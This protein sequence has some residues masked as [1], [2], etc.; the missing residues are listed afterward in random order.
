MTGHQRRDGVDWQW[1][2]AQIGRFLAGKP[3]VTGYSSLAAGTDQIFADVVLERGGKLIAVIPLEGYSAHF[4]AEALQHF[5]M[6]SSK[7]QIVELKSAKSDNWAFLDAGKWIVREADSII[8]VWDGEPA[9]G[10]GGTGDIVTYA[11]SVGKKVHHI[12]P[13]KRVTIDL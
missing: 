13:I 3:F 1:V 11:L 5:R 7:A 10:A 12:D 4:E 6:L 2:R 9:E 8:A